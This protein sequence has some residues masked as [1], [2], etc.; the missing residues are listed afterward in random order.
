[1]QKHQKYLYYGIQA[2]FKG[3]STIKN[4]LDFSKDKDPMENKI[5][6]SIGSNVGT[7]HVMRNT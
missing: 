3:T 7:L 5:G 2:H 4:F 6:P 1:M